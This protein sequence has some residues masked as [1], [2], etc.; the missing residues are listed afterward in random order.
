MFF[1]GFLPSRKRIRQ[2][3][4]AHAKPQATNH[5]EPQATIH[6]EPQATN[7]ISSAL[8]PERRARTTLAAFVLGLPLA[9]AILCTIRFGPY[10]DST[11]ARYVKHPAEQVEVIM[12]CMALGALTAKLM[13][14]GAER[15]ACRTAILPPCR[16][17]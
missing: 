11:A 4:S 8:Q 7:H 17:A 16:G 13:A 14:F 3:A 10:R 1:T 2:M 6:P 9:A 5:P 12:F 15:R